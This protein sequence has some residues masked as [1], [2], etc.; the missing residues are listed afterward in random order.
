MKRKGRKVLIIISIVV[1]CLAAGMAAVYMG[2]VA[3][4]RNVEAAFQDVDTV[5]L[6]KVVN[7]VYNG[8]AGVFICST[9]LDVTVKDHR[10]ADI[11]INRQMNGGGKYQADGML[12]RIIAAQSP[13]VDVVSGATLTSKVIMVAVHGALTGGPK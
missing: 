10:I 3:S 6:G 8:K 13:D 11:A 2:L 7:G 9:D 12:E 5:D 1:V 4:V